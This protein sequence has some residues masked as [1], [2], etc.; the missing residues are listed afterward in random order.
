MVELVDF[1]VNSFPFPVFFRI[2]KKNCCWRTLAR[3]QPIITIARKSKNLS[4]RHSLLQS[5]NKPLH[6][7][8]TGLLK[9]K[10]DI[11]M[12]MNQQHVTLLV[13]LDLRTA[14]DTIHHD[15]LIQISVSSLI[16]RSDLRCVLLVQVVF[17]R[18]V[19]ASVCQWWTFQE[20]PPVS[21]R[22]SKILLGPAALHHIYAQTI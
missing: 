19:P 13:L 7:S 18:Q 14:F 16:V 1:I 4:E 5:T 21:R 10:N 3:Q 15:M 6:S 11:L 17:I 2:F 12:S 8:E 20:V 22:P 9:V